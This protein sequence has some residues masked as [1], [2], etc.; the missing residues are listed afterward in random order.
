MDDV[1]ASVQSQLRAIFAG[2][3]VVLVGGP[4]VGATHRVAQLETVGAA[5]CL[6]VASSAGTG[7]LP[8]VDTAYYSI[9]E[10]ADPVAEFRA[11][12]RVFANP[13]ADVVAAI[14][15]FDPSGEAI[16]LAP[17]FFDVRSFGNRRVF[18]ARREEWVALEDKTRIDDLFD[19]ASV[20]RPVAEIVPADAAAIRESAARVDQGA[21]TVW[22][23]DARDGFNGGGFAVRWVRDAGDEEEALGALLARCDQVRVAAFADG[24]PCSVHGFVTD[25][26]VA[27]FR[28]VELITLRA[29]SAPRF[30]YAGCASFFD[31][32]P[33]DTDRMRAAVRRVGEVLRTRV[34]FRGAFTVDGI[35]AADGW[36]ATECN[37]RFGAA[38]GYVNKVV[39]DLSFGILHH[40][41]CEGR[42]T[43]SPA[44][45]EEL[46]LPAANQTRWGGAWTTVTKSFTETAT[47]DYDNP[48]GTLSYG[49]SGIGGFVRFEL[50]ESTP[51]GPSVAPIAVA[52]FAR[53]DRELALG[54]GA[55][56]PAPQVR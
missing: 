17:P 13:P 37:P 38:L 28:P 46:V 9:P 31:P 44:Q 2:R 20:Q 47:V 12:E 21:G 30:H 11:E 56:E 16:V 1:V 45:L 40:A 36:V 42:A 48:A 33:A 54:I 3:S 10:V 55:R 35:L 7:Q 24:I 39:P 22:A 23:A 52:A 41:V 26:G 27:V 15:R 25:D 4:A 51:S 8:D 50:P 53:A 18:G 32:P 14:D 19:A 6:V 5:R 43:A 49:P 29:P 34:D